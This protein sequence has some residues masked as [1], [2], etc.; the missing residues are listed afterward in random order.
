MLTNEKSLYQAKLILEC[1]PK[2]EY[3][4]IPQDVIDYLN[5]NAE[6]DPSIQVNP[7]VALEKQNIDTK[8]YAYL[9]KVLQRIQTN[10][11][12]SST[13]TVATAS[14]STATTTP[15]FQTADW[16]RMQKENESMK[17]EISRLQ[18]ELAQST[19]KLGKLTETEGLIHTYESL[20]SE[21]NETITK[22]TED[23]VKLRGYINNTPGWIRKFF[24]KDIN[25]MLDGK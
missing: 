22:L 9:G 8:T 7:H 12:T 16:E 15:S 20:V 18:T 25:L 23:N 1:L 13:T 3:A 14:T 4:L 5:Q 17:S 24:M 21:R 10:S 2:E 6:Y 19:M 11:N